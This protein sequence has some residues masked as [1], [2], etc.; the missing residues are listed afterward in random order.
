EHE[1]AVFNGACAHQNVPVR[2]AGLPGEGR[3]D[4]KECGAGFG[5]CAIER[6]KAQVVADGKPK[7]P[8]RQI[9]QYR[10]VARTIAA[11]LAIALAALEVDI[12]HVDLVVTR[13]DL[14]AAAAQ[15]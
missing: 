2:L 10:E 5:K 8:P 1:R 4:S 7:P 6:R 14:A 13:D 12:E 3:R 15:E 9:G 11:R